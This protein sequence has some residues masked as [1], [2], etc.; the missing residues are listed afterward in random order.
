MT[1]FS[2]CVVPCRAVPCRAVL[3][4][5][6]LY[7]FGEFPLCCCASESLHVGPVGIS[8]RHLYGIIPLRCLPSVIPSERHAAGMLNKV[9]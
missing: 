3:L 5:H 7:R 1:N 2:N 4:V 8:A 6:K 9:Q